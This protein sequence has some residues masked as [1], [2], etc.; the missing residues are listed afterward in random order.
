MFV[1][2]LCK[3]L[4]ERKIPYCL[5][6]G[7]AVALHGAIRGTL[8]IDLVT[9]LNERSFIGI[10]S[11]LGEMG[12]EARLPVRAR[13]VF[14]F[15]EEYITRRNLIA[16]SFVDP[17]HPARQVDVI[18]TEDLRSLSPVS[19]KIHGTKVRVASIEGL[20]QMKGKSN[21]PQDIEDIKAL[22]GLLKK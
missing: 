6:G 5:V 18:I 20:I 12:L 22:K 16:W 4:D 9:T 17:T 14:Q 3:K 21:R 1:L 11:L 8:D 13:E 19:M 10:E 2:E 15:R 7:T